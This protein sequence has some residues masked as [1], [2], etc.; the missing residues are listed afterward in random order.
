MGETASWT[1]FIVLSTFSASRSLQVVVFVVVTNGFYLAIPL[2]CMNA[3]D[4]AFWDKNSS[5][6]LHQKQ[7]MLFNRAC[8]KSLGE[9]CRMLAHSLRA[10]LCY[11]FWKET[12][13]V[14][15][16]LQGACMDV[17]YNII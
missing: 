6:I 7:T 5:M 9:R 14:I 17:R 11:N 16:F 4:G 8:I 13:L 3:L 12:L 10:C 15:I 2:A 1:S